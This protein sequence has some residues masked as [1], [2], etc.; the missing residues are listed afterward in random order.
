MSKDFILT[1]AFNSKDFSN[2]RL[3]MKHRLT[4]SSS[5]IVLHQ[6]FPLSPCPSLSAMPSSWE[7]CHNL[8]HNR[9]QKGKP[10][11]VFAVPESFQGAC[12]RHCPMCWGNRGNKR[13]QTPCQWGV[14]LWG[15][16]GRRDACSEPGHLQTWTFT[17]TTVRSGFA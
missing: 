1:M 2:N 9:T 14:D 6:K 3:F 4:H 10:H 7:I 11:C 17:G 13:T 8:A 12:S 5:L 16:T 15:Q